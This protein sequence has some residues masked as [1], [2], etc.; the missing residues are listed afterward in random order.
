MRKIDELLWRAVG[1]FIGS[2]VEDFPPQSMRN[3]PVLL[4]VQ[5]RQRTCDAA[6][7]VYRRI[8]LIREQFLRDKR[9]TQ[10]GRVHQIRRRRADYEARGGRPLLAQFA[11][12][13][14]G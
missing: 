13:A 10:A 1:R 11:R 2:G 7:V 4:A 6:D 8:T 5:Y 9:E 3:D 14:R 12:Q